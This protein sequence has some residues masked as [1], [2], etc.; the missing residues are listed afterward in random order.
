VRA[1]LLLLLVVALT[2]AGGMAPQ[3]L[4]QAFELRRADSQA[5][6]PIELTLWVTPPLYTGLPPMRLEAERPAAGEPVVVREPPRVEVPAGSEALAQLHHLA[7][8][9]EEFAIGLDRH[10][11]P[12]VEIAEGSAEASMVLERS[13]ELRIG[14][15]NEELG[16]GG[17]RRS[18]IR[19]RRSPS[20]RRRRRPTAACCARSSPPPTTTASRASRW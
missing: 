7:D 8:P 1:A 18:P 10:A 14:S 12:F 20:P 19:R 4:L 6:T 3:R 16:S 15:D 13:G 2:Q 9:A 5:V 11:Q 17:S